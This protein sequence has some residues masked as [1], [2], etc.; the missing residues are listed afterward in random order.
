MIFM[1]VGDDQPIEFV[2]LVRD[3]TWI[4]HLDT[5]TASMIAHCLFK[6]DTTV[7]HEPTVI[8]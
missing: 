8:G 6:G 7:H 4:R 3:K 5:G 1:R 2:T